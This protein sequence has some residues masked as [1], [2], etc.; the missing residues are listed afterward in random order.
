MNTQSR[1]RGSLLYDLW[2]QLALL[3]VVALILILL[4]AKYVW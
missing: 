3:A 4:A 2:A 1:G